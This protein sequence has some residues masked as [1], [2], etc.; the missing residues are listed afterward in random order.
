MKKNKYQAGDKCKHC[1]E[2]I[3]LV[4]CAFKFEKLNKP[5]FYLAYYK[6][7]NCNAMYMSDK[8]KITNTDKSQIY[9]YIKNY[10]TK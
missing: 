4:E 10:D 5:Y 9:N 7:S 8:L 1:G 2:S 6:C 3:E